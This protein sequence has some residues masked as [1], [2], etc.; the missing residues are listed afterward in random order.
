MPVPP[1]T[2]LTTRFPSDPNLSSILAL[3]LVRL[4]AGEWEADAVDDCEGPSAI[5]DVMTACGSASV[6]EVIGKWV[7]W[8]SFSG[9]PSP[10]SIVFREERE[11]WRWWEGR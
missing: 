10:A 4:E 2:S 8:V 5:R 1:K 7:S 11:Y 3:P 6:N 9:R